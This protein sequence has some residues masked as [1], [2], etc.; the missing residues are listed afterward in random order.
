MDTKIEFYK[1]ACSLKGNGFDFSV[2]KG[3][4]RYQYGQGL[5]DV[6]RGIVRYIIRVTQFLKT[7]GNEMHPNYF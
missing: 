3:T 5:S 1:T 6:L 7:G 2:F 4:S